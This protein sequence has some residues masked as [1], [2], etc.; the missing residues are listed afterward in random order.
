MD[1]SARK[2]ANRRKETCRRQ[3]WDLGSVHG[4]KTPKHTAWSARACGGCWRAWIARRRSTCRTDGSRRTCRRSQCI[5][6]GPGQSKSEA[7]DEMPSVPTS[8]RALQ[9]FH[10]PTCAVT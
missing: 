2:A 6:G 7:M 10:N 3:H 5:L 9:G 4:P 1:S 8:A